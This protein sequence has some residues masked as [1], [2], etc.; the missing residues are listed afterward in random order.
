MQSLYEWLAG[1]NDI[2]RE[3]IWKANGEI[4]SS[5][6]WAQLSLFQ[7]FFDQSRC[8]LAEFTSEL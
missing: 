5:Q 1:K 3:I 8:H 4:F 7:P 6:G 2:E